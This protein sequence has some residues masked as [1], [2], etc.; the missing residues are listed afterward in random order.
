MP[1]IQAV[2]QSSSPAQAVY[3]AGGAVRD[4]LLQ[5]ELHDLDFATAGEVRLLARRVA[6]AVGGAFYMLDEERDTARVVL[7]R[8][9]YEGLV[10][11][12]NRFRAADLAGDLRGRDFTVNAMALDLA[13]L[14]QVID[15][16]GGAADLQQKT[17]RMCSPTALQDDPVRSLRAVRVAVGYGLRMTAE[18]VRAVRAA[19]PCLGQVSAERQRDELFHILAGPRVAVAVRLLEQFGLLGQVLP[20]LPAL[21]GQAQGPPH[22]YDVWEHTLA[23]LSALENLLG[24]LAAEPI[25]ADTSANLL[26][27]LAALRLGRYRPQLSTWIAKPLTATRPRRALLFLAALYHDACK[28][29]TRTFGEDGRMHFYQHDEIGA[30]VM[31]TRAA[32]L[33]LSQDETAYLA[34]FV[35]RHMRVHFLARRQPVVTRRLIY[36]YFRDLGEVGVDVCLHSLADLLATEGAQV[37]AERW[38]AE[39]D[40]CRA[41]LEAWFEQPQQAVSPPRLINGHDL[42]AEFTLSPGPRLG[43]LLEAVREAQASGEVHTRAEALGL[44]RGILAG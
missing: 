13:N 3:L 2:Q 36:R 22:I 15:P 7:N 37:S 19:A 42:M 41:L 43:E 6:E 1:L 32:A 29:Q 33:A 26:T 8:A 38:A 27:G 17:L 20:E 10:L 9:P 25:P 40:V 39:L 35:R 34:K 4:L 14:N 30:Q 28:P 5:R 21:K 23:H 11:D 18:T 12:F 31:A 16:L 24:L 44:V